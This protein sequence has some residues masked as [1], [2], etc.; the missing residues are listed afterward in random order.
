[1][2]T[3]PKKGLLKSA[4]SKSAPWYV[5]LLRTSLLSAAFLMAA[6]SHAG[7]FINGRALTENEEE[8]FNRYYG[9][10]IDFKKV[11]IHNSA[12]GEFILKSVNATAIAVNNTIIVPK[13]LYE[14]PHAIYEE[15]ILAHEL[16]HVWHNQNKGPLMFKAFRQKARNLINGHD[17]DNLY[18]YEIVDGKAFD[19]YGIEQQASILADY[20]I[21]KYY[22]FSYV[23]STQSNE[24]L[25]KRYEKLLEGVIPATKTSRPVKSPS[26]NASA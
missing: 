3:E 10:T 4:F 19:E 16:G 8:T 18:K 13:H 21:L 5:K 6:A 17:A 25:K 7:A 9:Q 12:A 1:L 22:N 15:A 20:Y 23:S 14:G 2:K 11:R 24:E 26:I